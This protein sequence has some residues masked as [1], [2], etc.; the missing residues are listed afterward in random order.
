M[1]GEGY[2]EN[3]LYFLNEEKFNFN[4]KKEEMSILWHKRIGHPSDKIL[5]SLFNFS[6]LNNNDCEICKLGKHT[7]LPFNL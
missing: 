7:R 1:I 6:S 3:G 2:L 4:A 5:K